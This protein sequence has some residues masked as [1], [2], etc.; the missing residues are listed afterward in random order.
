MSLH[1][2]AGGVAQGHSPLLKVTI[3]W[4]LKESFR[5][6]EL[7]NTQINKL[8]LYFHTAFTN[9]WMLSIYT[10]SVQKMVDMKR[11]ADENEYFSRHLHFLN[12]I[13]FLDVKYSSFTKNRLS[14]LI[15]F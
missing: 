13:V 6:P 11:P 5:M 4:S 10:F 3:Q 1:E 8:I 15:S 9:C 12:I 2:G 7:L 14:H